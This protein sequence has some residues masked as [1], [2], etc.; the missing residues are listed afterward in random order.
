MKRS[1][2]PEVVDLKL[3][4]PEVDPEE[5]RARA[6]AVTD[7][8]DHHAMTRDWSRLDE[9]VED[10]FTFTK[11]MKGRVWI[12]GLSDEREYGPIEVP[13]EASAALEP[14]WRMVGAVGRAGRRWDLVEVREVRA[15]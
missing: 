8:L 7:L 2:R 3:A 4:A 9:E 11:I 14:G 15:V 5:V 6:A 1:R 10:L 12:E 13:A